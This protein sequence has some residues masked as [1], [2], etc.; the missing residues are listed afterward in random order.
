MFLWLWFT[1]QQAIQSTLASKT[2]YSAAELPQE[3]GLTS[4]ARALVVQFSTVFSIE[5]TYITQRSSN[6]NLLA[7]CTVTCGVHC[8]R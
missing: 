4:L 8:C 6:D 3:S 5:R 7:S 1:S 2:P